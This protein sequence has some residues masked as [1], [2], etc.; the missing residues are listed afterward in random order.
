MHRY[1]KKNMVLYLASFFISAIIMTMILALLD[2]Y[3]FG[4]IS[5]LCR[6]LNIQYFDFFKYFRNCLYGKD[7]LIYTFHKSLWNTLINFCSYDSTFITSI[8]IA[9]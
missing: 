7:S 2:I 8:N 9:V 3:P 5:I 1:F 6:D 4:R